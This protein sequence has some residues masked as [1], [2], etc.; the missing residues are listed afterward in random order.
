[1]T[2]Q[3]EQYE[4]YLRISDKKDVKLLQIV[5]EYLKTFPLFQNSKARIVTYQEYTTLVE[6]KKIKPP[7]S[8]WKVSEGKVGIVHEASY[9][10]FNTTWDLIITAYSDFCAGYNAAKSKK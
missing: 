1:M 7:L 9:N 2:E 4:L 8:H 5:T 10:K 6:S 3:S